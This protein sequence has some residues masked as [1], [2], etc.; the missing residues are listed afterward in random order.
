MDDLGYSTCFM[1]MLLSANCWHLLTA[2]NLLLPNTDSFRS[3]D[4]TGNFK[5]VI[6]ARSKMAVESRQSR[7]CNFILW[8][9]F[10]LDPWSLD[11]PPTSQWWASITH[12]W[13]YSPNQPW[14][15]SFRQRC[16]V[17][18]N[19]NSNFSHSNSPKIEKYNPAKIVINQFSILFYLS[20]GHIVYSSYRDSITWSKKKACH[21]FS[22]WSL[23]TGWNG[24]GIQLGT[25][26]KGLQVVAPQRPHH[27]GWWWMC[28]SHAAIYCN[29]I[30]KQIG[31]WS[32]WNQQKLDPQIQPNAWW[33]PR[34]L[35]R[36]NTICA[37]ATDGTARFGSALDGFAGLPTFETVS[38]TYQYHYIYI[39]I[40]VYIYICIY[41]YVYVLYVYMY[42]YI[43]IYIYV[44]R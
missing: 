42:M 16:V 11:T 44:Y 24:V 33:I 43:C 23:P 35:W 22:P 2:L 39:Y 36:T 30:I 9:Y 4:S 41:I 8:G 7:E 1:I 40:Y 14:L 19:D 20:G 34:R 18:A 15:P 3:V 25:Q 27:V 12:K 38:V 21:C 32:L 6:P 26:P 13:V 17:I 31:L 37:S 10:I 28:H 29:N 5:F